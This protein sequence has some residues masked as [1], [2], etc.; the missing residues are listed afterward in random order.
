MS[1]RP[2]FDRLKQRP[3][4]AKLFFRIETGLFDVLVHD[5]VRHAGLS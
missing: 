1:G 2:G 5:G 4:A 3:V